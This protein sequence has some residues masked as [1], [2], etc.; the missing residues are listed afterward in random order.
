MHAY[1]PDCGDNSGF[2]GAC[3]VIDD[4]SYGPI[5]ASCTCEDETHNHEEI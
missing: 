5:S 4:G 3:T 2:D 1:H